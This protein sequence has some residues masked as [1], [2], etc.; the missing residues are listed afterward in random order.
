MQ[1]TN[2]PILAIIHLS[3]RTDEDVLS[4]AEEE[5]TILENC[6]VDG[7][8]IENYHG[9]IEHVKQVLK[10]RDKIDSKMKVGTNIL[11]K[12]KIGINILPN[13]YEMAF[14]FA[15]VYGLDFIQLDYVAGKYLSHRGFKSIDEYNYMRFKN[16]YNHVSILGG[17]HPK[18]YHPVHDSVL[19]D[20]IEDGKARAH[21]I[22]VT[23]EGT[24]KETPLEKIKEFKA[25]CGDHPLVIGAGLTAQNVGEQ[26]QYSDGAIVGSCFKPGGITTQKI[27]QP[28][29][30]EF[31]NAVKKVRETL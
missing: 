15:D 11:S 8:I 26:L 4:R 9:S 5:I 31:M 30:E 6:N 12:M 1:F 10:I 23:G 29:V 17:V 7:I 3:G 13:F 21:A 22:V 19:K 28:L 24:G 25:L 27:N 2:K 20:D 14:A 18:Y 16:K